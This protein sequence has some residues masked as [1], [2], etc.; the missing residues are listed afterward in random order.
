MVGLLR[1]R[2]FLFQSYGLHAALILKETKIPAL[3]PHVIAL[4]ISRT[5]TVSMPAASQFP[6][7]PP[8]LSTSLDAAIPLSTSRSSPILAMN[9]ASS[10][11]AGSTYTQRP[12]PF[13]VG[14]SGWEVLR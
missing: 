10:S 12:M 5:V 2:P 1:Y 8:V 9:Y 6:T 11:P 14:P 3:S 4:Q 13:V 7:T